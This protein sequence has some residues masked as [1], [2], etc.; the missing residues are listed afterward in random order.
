METALPSRSKTIAIE[1]RIL[2]AAKCQ[3]C[4]AKMYPRS[5]LKPHLDRH[6]RRHDWFATEL[7]KLQYT[8][9]HMRDLS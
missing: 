2:E 8:M 3:Q 1:N 4:G 6:Q 9:Q 5:L 7:R